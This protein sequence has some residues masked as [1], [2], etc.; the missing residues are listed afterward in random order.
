LVFASSLRYAH[1]I[2]LEYLIVLSV[3]LLKINEYDEE[4]DIELL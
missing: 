1:F 2:I 3:S 4:I